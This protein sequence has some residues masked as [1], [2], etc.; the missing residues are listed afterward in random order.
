MYCLLELGPTD[1]LA[2]E[3]NLLNFLS[4]LGCL[5]WLFLIKS[6]SHKS[7][8]DV[9]FCQLFL[10]FFVQLLELLKLGLLVLDQILNLRNLLICEL[11]LLLFLRIVQVGIISLSDHHEL[12]LMHLNLRPEHDKLRSKFVHVVQNLGVAD[13]GVR[14]RMVEE[15]VWQL[16]L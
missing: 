1:Y 8:E 16:T 2:S 13:D 3:L 6:L 11:K 5:R 15:Q 14:A 4:F 12:L 9:L 7:G 10:G